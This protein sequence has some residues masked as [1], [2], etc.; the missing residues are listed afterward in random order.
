MNKKQLKRLK[1]IASALPPTLKRG[2]LVV[3]GD[4]LL[5]DYSEYVANKDDIVRSSRYKI[6]VPVKVDHVKEMAKLCKN[7]SEKD[8]NLAIQQY[9]D[10]VVTLIP[11]KEENEPVTD[12]A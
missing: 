12:P 5:S 6:K 8:S 2:E 10:Y 9:C 3:T 4:I 1:V 7:K 11:K